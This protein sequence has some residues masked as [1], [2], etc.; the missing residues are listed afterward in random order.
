MNEDH[1]DAVVV[2]L[3]AFGKSEDGAPI[4]AF[5]EATVRLLNIEPTAMTV[6]F[7]AAGS[8]RQAHIRFEPPVYPHDTVRG[9]LIKM[10]RA[11]R[12]ATNVD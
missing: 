1:A 5:D 6:A 8:T 9:R 3:R 10:T 7:T 11:A 12:A 4:T 2:M